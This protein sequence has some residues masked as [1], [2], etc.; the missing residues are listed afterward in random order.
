MTP[1]PSYPLESPIGA[2]N[3]ATVAALAE[4][5]V[6]SG[7]PHPADLDQRLPLY[8][9]VLVC[10]DCYAAMVTDPGPGECDACGAPDGCLWYAWGAAV[11]RVVV[12]VRVC[13]RCLLGTGNI[14]LAAN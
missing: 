7:C 1:A 2:L 11:F 3:H 9:G 13:P 5:R 8:L 10:A 12:I 6:P 4:D 14:S